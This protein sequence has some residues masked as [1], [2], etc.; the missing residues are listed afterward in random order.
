AGRVSLG[1]VSGTRLTITSDY[2]SQGGGLHFTTDLGGDASAPDQLVVE[3]DTSGTGRVEVANGAGTGAP[4]VNGIRL[5]DVA[6]ASNATFTLSGDAVV[7]GRPVV[8]AGAFA[9]S[10]LKG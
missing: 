3:G 4:T 10:L 7:D 2:A 9:Y 8:V 6:G 5:I 1:Q